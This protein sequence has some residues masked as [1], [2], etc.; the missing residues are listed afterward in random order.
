MRH[1]TNL[2]FFT[3]ALRLRASSAN[4][5][6]LHSPRTTEPQTTASSRA[7]QTNVN[8]P[9]RHAAPLRILP[10]PTLMPRMSNL[11]LDSPLLPI[12]PLAMMVAAAFYFSNPERETPILHA[13]IDL[14]SQS[15][16]K[17]MVSSEN[18]IRVGKKPKGDLSGEIVED[19]FDKTKR[20][21]KK[22]APHLEGFL[23]EFLISEFLE[24]IR[25]GVQPESLIM[26]EI[27]EN[28]EARFYT[29]SRMYPNTMDLED[30]VKQDDWK[31]KLAKKPLIGF[32]VAL[33]ADNIFAKQQ[34]M[35]LANYIVTEKE[36]GYYVASID[37][38]CAGASPLSF[39]NKRLFS[40]DIDFLTRGVRDLQPKDEY[41]HAGLA[42]DPRAKEFMNEAKKFMD[43]NNVIDF[44]QKVVAADTTNLTALISSIDGTGGLINALETHSYFME[45]AD[46]QAGAVKFLYNLASKK[47][48]EA[49]NI[50]PPNR[51]IGYSL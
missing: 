42:G 47:S 20:Y 18:Y 8:M 41:N 30:F 2:R 23:Q 40:I 12:F 9:Q 7:V 34:D 32:E 15:R 31:E 14:N 21:L 48:I 45:I 10:T 5:R 29:L 39:I 24:M 1:L 26:Q 50:A 33:A 16:K 22:G 3:Q 43:V 44:Y 28:G 35:K 49:E 51:S 25:P 38:E 17:F 27:Q 4:Y 46:I 19:K 6:N 13:P 11:Y 37:H 36:D